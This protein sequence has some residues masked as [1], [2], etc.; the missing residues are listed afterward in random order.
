[1][2][3]R[4]FAERVLEET[5]KFLASHGGIHGILAAADSARAAGNDFTR[6]HAGLEAMLSGVMEQQRLLLMRNGLE[7]PRLT[8]A[9]PS[10]Q[11]K[12]SEDGLS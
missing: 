3:Q 4:Q 6:R 10:N 1:M 5:E 8:D 7:P 9:S 11:A 12:D 2:D